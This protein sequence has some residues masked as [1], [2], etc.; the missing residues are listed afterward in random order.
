M[1]KSMPRQQPGRSKQDVRTP[2]VFLDAVKCRLGIDAFTVD[3]AASASNTVAKQFYS[4]R[5]NAL[6][7]PWALGGW[8]WLNPPFA[9]IDPWVQKAYD[10][11]RLGACTAMLLPAGVG[12]NW[13]RDWVHRKARVLL[14]NGRITFV[15]HATCYPKDCVLLLYAPDIVPAYESWT[16]PN[17]TKRA[18]AAAP[19]LHGPA[20]AKDLHLE[21]DVPLFQFVTDEAGAQ[22]IAAGVMPGYFPQQARDGL[23]MREPEEQ[24]QIPA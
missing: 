2:K 19:D 13:W 5:S 9:K 23:A 16:W 24:E 11:S 17:E 3:L 15:G 6:V 14:L 8:N 18:A 10:E 7:Q 20:F 21:P 22:C 1:A 4:E 12:A